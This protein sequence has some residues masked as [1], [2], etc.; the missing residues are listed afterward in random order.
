MQFTSYLLSKKNDYFSTFSFTSSIFVAV[1][2]IILNLKCAIV[3]ISCT[4][5]KLWYSCRISPPIVWYSSFSGRWSPKSSLAFSISRRPDRMYS[6]SPISLAMVDVVSCS[7]SI[8]PRISS[9]RSSRPQCL[10][11]LRTRQQRQPVIAFAA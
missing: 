10:R 4:F 3:M 6:S 9:T 2:L 11:F 7:S 1:T 8:S 5:G